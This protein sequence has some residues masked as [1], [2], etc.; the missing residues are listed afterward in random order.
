[1]S[2][3]HP[4]ALI[5]CAGCPFTD[6]SSGEFTACDASS[7]NGSPGFTPGR[8]GPRPDA[9]TIKTSPARAGPAAVTGMTSP[10][11]IAGELPTDRISAPANGVGWSTEKLLHPPDLRP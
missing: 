3:G 9:F 11:E 8:V 10:C 5:T 4:I 7:G 6:T 2:P 1:M